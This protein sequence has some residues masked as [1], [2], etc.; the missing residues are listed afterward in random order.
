MA[1]KGC[2]AE[3]GCVVAQRVE[4]GCGLD[5]GALTAASCRTASAAAPG[6][7]TLTASRPPPPRPSRAEKT[8]PLP[9]LPASSGDRSG[10][11][12]QLKRS[13]SST[14]PLD[15]LRR[16]EESG[17]RIA[18]NLRTR[19]RARIGAL[20]LAWWHLWRSALG[21]AASLQI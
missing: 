14:A 4:L 18:W 11:P 12:P 13:S 6:Q 7:A 21:S 15:N 19:G 1:G 10:T 8:T 17:V 5:G 3:K 16:A 2:T 9:P 20:P